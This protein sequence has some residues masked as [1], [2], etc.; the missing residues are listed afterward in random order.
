ME[1]EGGVPAVRR[2]EMGAATADAAAQ[3]RADGDGPSEMQS[4]S[5]TPWRAPHA[6]AMMCLEG[7]AV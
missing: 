3:R 2:H 6:V 1:A 5:G 7:E 4:A